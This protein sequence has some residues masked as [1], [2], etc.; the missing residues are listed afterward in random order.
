MAEKSK[1]MTWVPPLDGWVTLPKAADELGV[2]RQYMYQLAESHQLESLR[3]LPGSGDRPAAYVISW[4]ERDA[5]LAAQEREN[6]RADKAEADKA[7]P[8]P[9]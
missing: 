4:E 8:V 9:A 1:D 2:S 5:M 7:E 3:Q 6:S